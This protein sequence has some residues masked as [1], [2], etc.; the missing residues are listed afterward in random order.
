MDQQKNTHTHTHTEPCV[1]RNARV[2]A[3][4]DSLLRVSCV[5]HAPGSVVW[6]F[7]FK[8]HFCR[9]QNKNY[10]PSVRRKHYLTYGLSVVSTWKSSEDFSDFDHNIIF[11]WAYTVETTSSY[12]WLSDSYHQQE[13]NVR[14]SLHIP[15]SG[16]WCNIRIT[17]DLNVNPSIWISIN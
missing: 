7:L 10:W 12:Q 16:S 1:G 17:S 5:I 2:F 15:P 8:V 9:D 3:P 4:A 11:I 14:C 6:C 13:P